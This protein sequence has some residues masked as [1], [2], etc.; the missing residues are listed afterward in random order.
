[1]IRLFVIN[2]DAKIV[3]SYRITIKNSFF[4]RIFNCYIAL[5]YYF[6]KSF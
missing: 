4:F 1:M 5:F 2:A 6:C 3:L